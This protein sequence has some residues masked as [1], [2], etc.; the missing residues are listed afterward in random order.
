[1]KIVN[2]VLQI[3]VS[4]QNKLDARGGDHDP[5]RDEGSDN[6]PKQ[7]VEDPPSPILQYPA[8]EHVAIKR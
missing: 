4:S 2:R 6:D 7:A 5:K 8:Q 3:R 1:M